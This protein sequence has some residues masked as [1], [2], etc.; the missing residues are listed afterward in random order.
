MDAGI[1][2]VR[3]PV[4]VAAARRQA[5]RVAVQSLLLAGALTGLIYAL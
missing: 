5:T 3:D 2:S 1:E 4:A